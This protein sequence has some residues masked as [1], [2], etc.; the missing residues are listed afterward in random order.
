[1]P[2]N[3]LFRI[4]IHTPE[5]PFHTWESLIQLIANEQRTE[6]TYLTVPIYHCLSTQLQRASTN[7]LKAL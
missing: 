6:T 3:L 2:C 5:D 4:P 1:M 7:I